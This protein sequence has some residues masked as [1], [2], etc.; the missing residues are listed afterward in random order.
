[1]YEEYNNFLKK[2]HSK[3]EAEQTENFQARYTEALDKRSKML[4][5][6]EGESL[7]LEEMSE[8]YIQVSSDAR[9]ANKM[10]LN[11]RTKTGEISHSF[12]SFR[13]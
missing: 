8:I 7:T 1:M 2:M 11:T 6:S 5:E 10:S 12:Y 9:Q 4:N 13:L 3:E